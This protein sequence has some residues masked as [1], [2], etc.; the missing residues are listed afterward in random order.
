MLYTL[1]DETFVLLFLK[2]LTQI[3]S[4]EIS[5]YQGV[6]KKRGVCFNAHKTPPYFCLQVT[7]KVSSG[8][9]NPNTLYF[10]SCF[11]DNISFQSDLM[12][13]TAF[14]LK[15]QDHISG[16]STKVGLKICRI[17]NQITCS[18]T[19]LSFYHN[20]REHT[21]CFTASRNIRL[22]VNKNPNIQ[23]GSYCNVKKGL[24]LIK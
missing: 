17:G 23:I 14:H 3:N 24:N 19:A 5:L 16:I 8:H 21:T 4:S 1:C 22:T 6:P 10:K 11:K 13:S 15:K 20:V 2:L 18:K 9:L 12:T 7:P